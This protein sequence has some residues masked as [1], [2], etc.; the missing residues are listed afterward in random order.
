MVGPRHAYLKLKWKL[1]NA[2]RHH[3]DTIRHKD[4]IQRFFNEFSMRGARKDLLK[5]AS[6]VEWYRARSHARELAAFKDAVSPKEDFVYYPGCYIDFALSI[7]F[8]NSRVAYL[9]LDKKAINYLKK[10]GL[11]A[12]CMN[13]KDY[14]PDELPDIICQFDGV[15]TEYTYRL[16]KPGGYICLNNNYYIA[17]EINERPEFEAI[18]RVKFDN[19]TRKLV[20]DTENP[21]DALKTVEND[22]EFKNAYTRRL[23]VVNY[24]KAVELVKLILGEESGSMVENY[25]KVLEVVKADPRSK[26]NKDGTIIYHLDNPDKY[27]PN[28]LEIPSKFP[29]KGESDDLYIFQRKSS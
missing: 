20:L 17:S 16:V 4:D 10:F 25:R 21:E 2:I 27:A 3:R 7:A 23:D 11:E 14:L 28:F 29:P 8:P 24:N 5:E 6:K 12:L 15:D 19:K 22:D 9:D 26:I 1:K 13:A 18:G